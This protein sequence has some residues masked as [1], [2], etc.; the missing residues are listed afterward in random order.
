PKQT[1]STPKQTTSTPKQT[2]STPKQTT[3]TPKQTTSTP[4]QTTSTPKQT[5]STPKQTTSIPKQTTSIPKQTTSTPKQTTSTPKQTTSTPKQTTSTPKQT[6]STPKQTT[7]TPKQTTSTPK[8]TTSTPKQTTSTPKQTTSTPKQTTSTPKQTTSIPKQTT[9]IPKQTTS[10]PK[11]TTSTPKQTTSTPK[12][13]TSTP[14]QT[15]SIPKQTT[16][17]PKQTTST[18]KQTTSTPKQTTSTP[19]KG[20]LPV[21]V[22]NNT[23]E[24]IYLTATTGKPGK[25]HTYT[26]PK[27]STFLIHNWH[28]PKP[29]A[30]GGELPTHD[31]NI[32][33][34]PKG[35][36][37]KFTL[38]E[39]SNYAVTGGRI[40]A[41][42][43][44]QGLPSSDSNWIPSFKSYS[45]GYTELTY[46]SNT[47]GKVIDLTN[48]DSFGPIRFELDITNNKNPKKVVLSYYDT[49]YNIYN[50]LLM[51]SKG[52]DVK[53]LKYP[54]RILSP[55]KTN[56]WDHLL[57]QS[58]IN[59]YFET[60]YRDKQSVN[61]IYAP[62][63]K[64]SYHL[65]YSCQWAIN[66]V[67]CTDNGSKKNTWNYNKAV[68]APEKIT[69]F[70]AKAATGGGNLTPGAVYKN[71]AP[72]GKYFYTYDGTLGNIGDGTT[73]IPGSEADM[74]TNFISQQLLAGL[75][76]NMDKNLQDYSWVINKY[77]AAY[78]APNS[79]ATAR[80]DIVLQK[81]D[82]S[83]NLVIK[84]LPKDYKYTGPNRPKLSALSGICTDMVM[85]TENPQVGDKNIFSNYKTYATITFFSIYKNLELPKY[86]AITGWKANSKCESGSANLN[87]KPGCAYTLTNKYSYI[88]AA[89]YN[90]S[91][92]PN[93]S[94][95]LLP[96]SKLKPTK[97]TI[98]YDN[99]EFNIIIDPKI[100]QN[101]TVC[102]DK[103]YKGTG[104][105]ITK[106]P[107]GNNGQSYNVNISLQDM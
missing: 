78:S 17:T 50:K 72:P 42:Y 71:T 56:N 24:T 9:S 88:G 48:V 101:G 106:K 79:D 52:K 51:V 34:M 82:N 16:S 97:Y 18:P 7:S 65:S 49:Y 35:S 55:V 85:V 3:S 58:F 76:D 32:V 20:T 6:T 105:N 43:N 10:T 30:L 62:G 28:D 27:Q 38:N 8:Q 57:T 40:Y 64:S 94:I 47:A 75:K 77:S 54:N 22:Q 53:D 33:I 37:Y 14:K 73:D 86:R 100:G 104:L 41:S 60:T 107:T 11:Q 15:T 103:A 45:I 99:K 90:E 23:N 87:I 12:Q 2:T 95:N 91:T 19:T 29:G 67:V 1:T 69:L 98:K 4:K 81:L 44:V 61:M 80:N 5:T 70:V 68:T 102:I 89:T 93:A 96:L 92:L 84:I 63:E 83:T 66:T 13:T 25:M 31:G 26:D 74:V 21:T 59:N 46:N 39:K 36:Q